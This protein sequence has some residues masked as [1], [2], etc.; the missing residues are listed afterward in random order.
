MGSIAMTIQEKIDAIRAACV[1]ANPSIMDLTFGCLVKQKY[2]VKEYV[3]VICEGTSISRTDDG[4]QEY[5]ITTHGHTRDQVFIKRY[6]PSDN[7]IVEILGRPV[8]LADVLFSRQN[9]PGPIGVDINGYFLDCDDDMTK[10]QILEVKWNLIKDD[11][12]DQSPETIEFIYSL[13]K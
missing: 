2:S 6:Y 13:L 11:L 12:R 7:Y 5:V 10:I 1:A 4:E 3:P 8:R 9:H